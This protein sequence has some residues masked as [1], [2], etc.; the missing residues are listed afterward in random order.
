[1]YFN[2]LDVRVATVDNVSTIY[3]KES[4]SHMSVAVAWEYC[5]DEN[6]KDYKKLYEDAENVAAMQRATIA[7]LEQERNRL[8]KD[9]SIMHIKLT[10][11][12]RILS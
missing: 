1:V 5:G 11:A 10:Q 8:S 2:G 3:E 4:P 12:Y 6:K 7:T 9:N